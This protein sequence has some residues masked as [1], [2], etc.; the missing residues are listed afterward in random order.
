M[1]VVALFEA[2]KPVA[3]EAGEC[4]MAVYENA[5]EATT[6]AD[7]SP[8]TEADAAAERVILK[9][10]A[11]LAPDIPVVSEENASSHSLAVTSRFFLVDPLDG[12]KEFMKRDGQGAFTVNIGLVDHGVPIAGLVF[13]P[14]LDRLFMGVSGQNGDASLAYEE[15]AGIRQVLA[16]RAVPPAHWTAV[17]SASH[18]DAQTEAW[19]KDHPV[20]GTVSVGSSL[21]FCLLAGGEADVYPRFGPTME[22]DTCAGDAVLRA[23]GGSVKH[24][25]GGL[26]NYG[27]P[28]YRNG[29]FVAWGALQLN[30]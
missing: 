29:A 28:D 24:P 16:V 4:I 11:A 17:A 19:L 3:R 9:A 20:G 30:A 27:K 7:G 5:P 26:F 14:A 2:L 6:K 15:C 8:V 23:A 12:T 13:A 25:A 22:W 21:K 18:R 1:N 10:L